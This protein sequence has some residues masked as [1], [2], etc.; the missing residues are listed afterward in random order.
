M[1]E[2]KKIN[3]EDPEALPS[4]S[5][6][7]ED[8]DCMRDDLDSTK[9]QLA[10]EMKK[11]KKGEREKKVMKIDIESLQSEVKKLKRQ[12]KEAGVL[13]KPIMN[14][15]DGIMPKLEKSMSKLRMSENEELDFGELDNIEGEINELNGQIDVQRKRAEGLEDKVYELEQKLKVSDAGSDEW[16]GRAIF[17]EKKYK[18]MQ[19][20]QNIE[21]PDI[22]MATT[23]TDPIEFLSEEN[24]D[25]P[26]PID[27]F[28]SSARKSGSRRSF[29][30]QFNRMESFQEELDE[31]SS[32]SSEES[33]EED[34]EEEYEEEQT[35]D[36]EEGVGDSDDE[37]DEEKLA[38]IAVKDAKRIE[39]ESEFWS[40]KLQH[41]KEKENNVL[42]ERNNLRDRIKKF[43][44]DMYQERVEFLKAKAELDE[45]VSGLK[46]ADSEVEED[47]EEDEEEEEEIHPADEEPGWWFDKPNL[48]PKKLKK[49]SKK[50][51]NA[52]GE[53]I[54]DAE[55]EEEENL[56]DLNQLEEPC[57]SDSE[58]EESDQD[59]ENDLP[60]VKL[61]FLQ[62][63]TKNHEEKMVT[64]KKGNYLLK[65]EADRCKENLSKERFRRRRLD[66]EL[67]MLLSDMQ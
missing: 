15:A 38:R 44:R 5:D 41:T 19:R 13:E 55:E 24:E 65:T 39:R 7:E 49:K 63:R 10:D 59:D 11:G 51:L 37:P 12:L 34:D 28:G 21:L 56:E 22:S 26:L 67:N 9:T 52:D 29:A 33:E 23:Q 61:N 16:E 1:D 46:D 18:A 66:E 53:I 50:K 32:S 54:D 6:D 36:E 30:S 35:V 25:H 45:L 3:P 62:S 27:G 42:T 64:V 31:G 40:N 58:Q 14:G 47:E 43:Y 4:S 60:Q 20:D 8:I 2:K 48:K 57:W 17:F